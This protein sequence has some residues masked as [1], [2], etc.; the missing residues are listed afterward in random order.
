MRR[1][2]CHLATWANNLRAVAYLHLMSAS[3][4]LIQTP[5]GLYCAQGDFHIDPTRPV[6]RAL[7]THGHSDHARAGH[8]NVLATAQTLAIMGLRYGER[9]AGSTQAIAYGEAL[10]LGDV[11]VSF[12]P[13]GHVLG[14]AQILMDSAHGRVVCSGDY[15]RARDPTCAPL[16]VLRC[17]AFI[18]EATFGL[19]VFRHPDTRLEVAKLIA[20]CR[21]FPERA[22]L[23]GAYSLGKA[24]RLMALIREAG[25]D[26]P[27][28]IHGAV[29]KITHYYQ[30]QGIA[31]GEIR[32]VA[33]SDRAQLGG[34]III[35][36]PSAMQD[37]W[38]SK[39]PDPVTAF[40]SG[41]MRVRARARQRGVSLPLVVSDHADWDDLCA[42][43]IETG[44]S[45][46]WVTHGA[47]DALVHWASLRGLQARPLHMMGYGDEEETTNVESAA[48]A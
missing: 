13:A 25:W 18:T 40:A 4:L 42:T 20:S 26:R 22:H 3:D 30:S 29:E 44:C 31:L 14:S 38:A 1:R 23:V 45:E 43:V 10:R 11:E 32:K 2:P 33:A 8:G 48:E 9:F 16:E 35:C 39:F 17:D 34:E 47:E 12:H 41:W 46:V 19:P 24:Q 7:I 6:A 5:E 36:P 27:I 15:K 28:W 37:L 21:L